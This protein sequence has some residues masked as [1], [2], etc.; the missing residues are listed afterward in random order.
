ML[1]LLQHLCKTVMF[2]RPYNLQSY[3]LAN[4]LG[5]SGLFVHEKEYDLEIKI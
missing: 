1:L 2:F 5:N 4:K 3:S